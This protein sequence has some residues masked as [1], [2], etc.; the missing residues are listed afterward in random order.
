MVTF[1]SKIVRQLNL[2]IYILKSRTPVSYSQIKETFDVYANKKKSETSRKLFER[3]KKDLRQMGIPLIYDKDEDTYSIDKS[4]FYIKKMTFN[5]EEKYLLSI[6]INLLMETK[7]FPVFQNELVSSLQKLAAS[8]YYKNEHPGGLPSYMI[9]SQVKKHDSW[10]D[11]VLSAVSSAIFDRNRLFFEYPSFSDENTSSR[12]VDPLGMIFREGIPYLIAYCHLRKAVRIFNI[13][14]MKNLKT[15][16]ISSEEI[17]FSVP[18]DFKIEKYS[19][20]E[21]WEFENEPPYTAVIR[22]SAEIAWMIENQFSNKTS[23]EKQD[24][25]D[26]LFKPV[27]SNT[28]GITSFILS[29]GEKAIAE[30]PLKLRQ[31]IKDEICNI[32][33]EYDKLL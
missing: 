17:P 23:L 4:R 11:S 32:L 27:V 10:H 24:S 33:Y 31:Y 26:L 7:N 18:K 9:S 8:G 30:E 15:L 14:R 12:H 6:M 3:D 5:E 1:K 13:F 16:K 25:G 28:E 22:F 21:I 19:D 2:L 20:R 29:F